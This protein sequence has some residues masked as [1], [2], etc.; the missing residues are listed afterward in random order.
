MTTYEIIQKARVILDND[1]T[2][3]HRWS[4]SELTFYA[5]LS[6]QEVCRRAFLI[7]DDSTAEYCTVSLTSDDNSYTLNE[8][9]IE[10]LRARI[11]T[12]DLPM[13]HMTRR[14][15][16]EEISTWESP[17]STTGTPLYFITSYGTELTIVPTPDASYTLYLQVVRFPKYDMAVPYVGTG[18]AFDATA[19]TITRASGGWMTDGYVAGASIYISGS[20]NTG[21]NGTKTISTITNTVITT[22]ESLTDESA[23]TA[24][25]V[26]STPEIPLAFHNDLVYYMAH[27]A[28]LKNGDNTFN[29]ELSMLYEKKF[30]DIF[31]TRPNA[32][33]EKAR[34]TTP[35]FGGMMAKKYWL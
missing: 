13:T 11:S 9:V 23:G 34:R 6:E 20:S 8:K 4:D 2:N 30:Q 19:K 26:S 17:S 27:L 29:K 35:L 33:V 32:T 22:S 24:V 28:Y 1:P 15:M 3:M 12:E 10:V 18:L 5:N 25:T 14:Q 16:D 21:N 7:K 31:G